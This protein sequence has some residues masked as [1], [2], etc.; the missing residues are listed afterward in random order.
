MSKT[1]SPAFVTSH[2]HHNAPSNFMDKLQ[3]LGQLATTIATGGT[4]HVTC[5]TFRV[6]SYVNVKPTADVPLQTTNVCHELEQNK[7]L[8]NTEK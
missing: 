4:K 6:H 5:K 7:F 2:V 8:L 3:R 1:N